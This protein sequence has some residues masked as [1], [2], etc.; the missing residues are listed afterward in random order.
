MSVV[1]SGRRDYAYSGKNHSSNR[2]MGLVM[3]KERKIFKLLSLGIAFIGIPLLLWF[4]G[5]FPKRSLLMD[6]LSLLTILAFSLLL[7]QFFLARTNRGLVKKVKMSYVLKIHK[8]I[9]YVFISVIML[10]PFFIIVPKF[11][12]D[13]VSP[14]DAFIRLITTFNTIGLVFGLVAYTVM[15]VIMVTSFFRFK[16]HLKYKT[17][18]TFHAY[19]TTIFVVAAT[20][21]VITLGRHSNSA[22]TMFY[23]IAGACGIF[24]LLRTYLVKPTRKTIKN[25]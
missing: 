11:L 4:L 3:Q 25:V 9:G 15:L 24:Y 1:L 17:W 23:V 14:K 20:W 16:L 22:F 10:H 18:R 19:L 7:A 8:F 21:H 6:S 5:D 13:A 12:D 2:F